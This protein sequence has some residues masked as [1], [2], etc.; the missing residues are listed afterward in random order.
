MAEVFAF[1]ARAPAEPSSADV[2]ANFRAGLS[3]PGPD[4]GLPNIVMCEAADLAKVLD[5]HDAMLTALQELHL[6]T[7]VGTDAERHAALN[8][9]WDAIYL[10]TGGQP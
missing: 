2:V 10:T 9:A 4:G 5:A 8:Q 1:P 3:K 7:V 6:R